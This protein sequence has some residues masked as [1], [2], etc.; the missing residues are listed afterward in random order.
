MTDKRWSQQ[1]TT[2]RPRQH[3]EKNDIQRK[4]HVLARDNEFLLSSVKVVPVIDSPP[5]SPMDQHTIDNPQ[6]C[7]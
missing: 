1:W 6:H 4:T 7:T 5:Y 2:Q 3:T